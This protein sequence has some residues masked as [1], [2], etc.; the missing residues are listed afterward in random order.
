M[1]STN[2]H[3]RDPKTTSVNNADHI[4]TIL[5]F[6]AIRWFPFLLA[7]FDNIWGMIILCKMLST[8][9]VS[10]QVT[11]CLSISCAESIVNMDLHKTICLV[12]FLD[13]DLNHPKLRN[14]TP[15]F[16]FLFCNMKRSHALPSRIF[17]FCPNVCCYAVQLSQLVAICWVLH[18][19]STWSQP[20]PGHEA[21][22]AISCHPPKVLLVNQ[23]SKIYMVKNLRLKWAS[24]LWKS[25][26]SWCSW[27]RSNVKNV[28]T[29]TT[30]QSF[31]R[32]VI[33]PTNPGMS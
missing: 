31:Q 23:S 15:S 1:P 33:L 2:S 16:T 32:T 17:N 9:N 24:F 25:H 28:K 18:E 26:V 4:S 29:S 22:S 20:N 10:H 5:D 7:T 8:S 21:T 12:G 30:T 3:L 14:N 19:E 13:L 6:W 11:V 27:K